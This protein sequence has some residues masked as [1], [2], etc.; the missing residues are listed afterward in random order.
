[1]FNFKIHTFNLAFKTEVI[2]FIEE[3]PSLYETAK[4]F[5]ERDSLPYDRSMLRQ[6]H[7]NRAKIE[8]SSVATNKRAKGAGRKPLL[9]NQEE[10]IYSQVIEMRMQNIKVKR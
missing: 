10:I 7:M 5:E 9:G 8:S 2:R 3:G 4:Y 6:R 1:M